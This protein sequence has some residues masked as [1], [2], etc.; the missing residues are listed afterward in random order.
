M[1][2]LGPIGDLS[3]EA[4]AILVENNLGGHM[5]AFPQASLRALP[6]PDW[7][8]PEE[9]STTYRDLRDLLIFSVDPVVCQDIDDALSCRNLDTDVYEVGVHIADV[10]SFVEAGSAIDN[11]AARRCTSVY[12]QDRR[13]D[14]LPRL[15]CEDLCSLRPHVNRL[16]VSVMWKIRVVDDRLDVEECWHGRSVINS[17]HALSYNQAQRLADG[18]DPGVEAKKFQDRSYTGKFV[19][20]QKREEMQKALIGL[21]RIARL[22][23]HQRRINGALDL[24]GDDEFGFS[25][26][27]SNLPTDI[28]AHDHLEVHSTIE[29]LMIMANETVAKEIY[30]KFPMAALLRRHPKP[31]EAKLREVVAFAE[32]LGLHTPFKTESNAAIAKS[33]RTA[34]SLL[35]SDKFSLLNDCLKRSIAEAEYFCTA[36]ISP[37]DFNHFGLGLEFYTHFTSPIRRYAD[38]VVHRLLLLPIKSHNKPAESSFDPLE[39]DVVLPR[40]SVPSV[41]TDDDL[42]ATIGKHSALL[43]AYGVTKSLSSPAFNPP[44]LSVAPKVDEDLDLLLTEDVKEQGWDVALGQSNPVNDDLDDLLGDDVEFDGGN[45]T[46]PQVDL[47][48]LLA[49]PADASI[50]LLGAVK[51]SSD[52][53]PVRSPQEARIQG[54]DYDVGS[55]ELAEQCDL[56]NRQHR[57]AKAASRASQELYLSLLFHR[58][59]QAVQAVIVDIL[60]PDSAKGLDLFI[61]AYQIKLRLHFTSSDDD[62]LVVAAREGSTLLELGKACY[63]YPNDQTIEL[64]SPLFQRRTFKQLDTIQV[65]VSSADPKALD[66]YA[67]IPRP[68]ARLLSP[69]VSQA[70]DPSEDTSSHEANLETKAEPKATS[71]S[72]Q[73]L[74]EAKHSEDYAHTPISISLANTAEQPTFSLYTTIYSLRKARDM[75]LEEKCSQPSKTTPKKTK[76]KKRGASVVTAGRYNFGFLRV[77]STANVP[78][79]PPEVRR[80]ESRHV[81]MTEAEVR[82]K[83]LEITRRTQRLAKEKRNERI[84]NRKRHQ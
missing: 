59:P 45:V 82:Q 26:D 12:L 58:A 22:R 44:A 15:L 7:K 52:G 51:P 40:S 9:A 74:L 76:K 67:R 79:S 28:D 49:G 20:V 23:K 5:G 66:N 61:P 8:V 34:R 84:K 71:D 70:H 77:T 3:T 46:A 54:A 75:A 6:S 69:E 14:M 35:E 78:V 11:E 64:S 73:T 65:W 29:E 16:A 2:T 50:D 62:T 42:N 24:S 18:G 10:T 68:T 63:A 27:G 13:L 32:K 56:I 80:R 21:M 39:D 4:A 43:R 30:Q 48:D 72:T 31:E 38:V 83:T 25:L 53:S 57:A 41:L 60:R 17:T 37:G 19:P 33:M 47:D 1:K 55:Q 81:P 36:G